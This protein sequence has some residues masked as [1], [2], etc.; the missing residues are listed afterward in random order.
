[1]GP[2]CSRSV[3]LPDWKNLL[4]GIQRELEFRNLLNKQDK[5]NLKGWFKNVDN[6]PRIAEL[7]KH[8]SEERYRDYMR[9]LFDPHKPFELPE[10]LAY[11]ENLP[12]NRIVTTNFD[13]VLEQALGD[14]WASHTWQD[15]AELR[16]FLR[17]S[18]P[19]IVH[20][21]GRIDQVNSLIHT[22]SELNALDNTP[23]EA[24]KEFLKDLFKHNTILLW[25]YSIQDP[26]LPWLNTQLQDLNLHWYLLSP[27]PQEEDYQRAQAW[28]LTLLPYPS[29]SHKP[30]DKRYIEG[31]TQWFATL[32]DL[33]DQAPIPGFVHLTSQWIAQIA[34]AER[35]V[36]QN[37][38]GGA[39][40]Q[41]SLIKAGATAQR[42]ATDDILQKLA[43]EDK[44][45][46]L[47]T[48][49]GGEGK[50]TLLMQVAWAL[51]QQDFEVFYTPEP[52]VD[53][54]QVLRGLAGPLAILI[55]QADLLHKHEL[56]A[57]LDFAQYR[58]EPTH[59]ILAA[60]IHEWRRV[61]T[62]NKKAKQML[63]SIRL[64]S[65]LSA[66]EA[67]TIAQLLIDSHTVT[68]VSLERLL[69]RLMD[70]NHRFLLAAMLT[71]IHSKPLAAIL[72]AAVQQVA[73][74]PEA[75]N[76]LAALGCVVTLE[77][78][79]NKHGQPYFCSVR[80]FKETLAITSSADIA[81]LCA[82]LPN[83]VQLKLRD[84]Y[85]V[86]TRHPL[87]AKTLLPILFEGDSPYLNKLEIHKQL[88]YAASRLSQTH[89]KSSE[90]NFMTILPL[91]H[92]KRHDYE[93]ARILYRLASE[94]D[95]ADAPTWQAWAVLE[96]EQGHIGK[97]DEPYTA[98]WLFKQGMEANPKDLPTWQSWALL[99]KEQHN[100]GDIHQLYTARW[101]LKQGTE[102]H[103]KEASIWQAW[104][105]LEQEQGNIGEVNQVHSARWLFKQ[106][107]K[108]DAKDAS[109]WQAWGLLEQ[110]Q[111]NIGEMNRPY[112]ARW[113]FKQGSKGNSKHAPLWQ[114]WGLLE[115]QMGHVGDINQAYTARW[116][117]KQATAAN[118]KS[119]VTWEV[120]ALLEHQQDNIG[121][122]NQPYTARWLF[123]QGISANPKHMSIWRAW[124]SMEQQLGY[125]S[126]AESVAQQGLTHHAN[127]PELIKLLE[128][129]ST[130]TLVE[131]NQWL[132]Q[133]ECDKVGE[134]LK[135]ALLANPQDQRLLALWHQWQQQCDNHTPDEQS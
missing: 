110:A 128:H 115:Q 75:Q 104:A 117:F 28:R 101:L 96:K 16:Y 124:A 90:R 14:N 99:E 119:V 7:L 19:L 30:A 133:G 10:Y 76:L 34:E 114:A 50:T 21:Y 118:P 54:A 9:K 25:G 58:S 95:P 39:A 121:E 74:H 106:G 31:L 1:I 36:Q 129:L 40:C 102:A 42:R 59:I 44:Q 135:E 48:A 2:G 108:A 120:W 77:A 4:Q 33:L 13:K 130:D 87:I 88:I 89:D 38:Y 53:T 111:G 94:T 6:F 56:N 68:E 35:E 71:T 73:Q 24:V 98:R 45:A 116:L 11:L 23:G 103:P 5:G 63:H 55:D 18:K 112:T 122:V 60:R 32:E 66:A 79:K 85:R 107:T 97:V 67:Q 86:E 61:Q 37:Y 62:N 3:G 51:A 52:Q 132:A 22:H 57:L 113:L 109:T 91:I 49:A 100:I 82:Q 64:T 80:L 47:L 93:A 17:E 126:Q 123:K 70:E 8:R 46:I 69:E 12:I 20:L 84:D 65:P 43:V 92:Q 131:V 81:A 78:H 41:W 72:E 105:L 15:K 134:Y 29:D 83:P 125:Y 26:L 127:D 27:D